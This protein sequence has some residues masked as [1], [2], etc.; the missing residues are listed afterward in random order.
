MKTLLISALISLSIISCAQE[1]VKGNGNKKIE[2][3]TVEANFTGIGSEGSFDIL[4]EDGP[5]DGIIYLEGDSNILEK[6]TTEIKGN[7]LV[8]GFRKGFN[9]KF[10][11]K[12]KVRLKAQ[13]LKSIALSG[14][15]TIKTEGV[16]K[17]NEMSISISGSG[18]IDAKV[19]AEN[20]T[21]AISGS[22]DVYLSGTAQKL[23]VGTSGSGDVKAFNLKCAD[24]EVGISGSGNT[25]I[26]AS[27]SISGAIAGSGDIKYK[28]NPSKIKVNSAGSGDIIDAN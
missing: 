22:G 14:S 13:N 7:T 15:G 27:N 2:K 3:R 20:I 17:A 6:I 12:I 19:A 21:T 16:Q 9:L 1:T 23:K 18:D 28:G 24:L 4:I 26:T 8:I 10:N 25:E 5:Q 11:N